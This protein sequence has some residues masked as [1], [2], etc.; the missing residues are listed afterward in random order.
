MPD[1]AQ[2]ST[3]Q[4]LKAAP[5]AAR[6]KAFA[7]AETRDWPG[8]FKA[9]AGREP[10]ETLIQALDRFD[11][12]TKLDANAPF[13]IDLGCGEG[14]DTAEL[15]RRGWRVLA[16]D[17]HPMGLDLLA[18]RDDIPGRAKLQTRLADFESIM[19]NTLPECDLLNASF[20]LPFCPPTSFPILWTELKRAIKPGGRFA[21]QLFGDRDTWASFPDRSHHAH[22]AALALL[23]GLDIERFDEDDRE[24]TD[25]H[26]QAK[27][28]HVFHI[29]AR[30]P[31]HA[32]RR[33]V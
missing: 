8:Y 7:C 19:P 9:T 20:S 23:E 12:T 24:G 28:W 1:D 10:R 11:A 5:N 31:D 25:C 22:D 3:W 30:K 17:G 13:A 27:H 29:I 16:I 21:G 33:T 18:A 4:D 26:E 32:S 15:L 14:R 2:Q 6:P